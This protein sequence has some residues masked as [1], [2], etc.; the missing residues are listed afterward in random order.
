MAEALARKRIRAGHEASATKT[1]RQIE[2]ILTGDD[3][4]KSRLLLL[5]LTL[6]ENLETIKALDAEVIE[7]IED[8]TLADEI[9]QADDYREMTFASLIK[10]DRIVEARDPPRDPPRD[11]PVDTTPTGSRST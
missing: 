8:D 10:I 9:E 5:R 3:P 7:L 2:E 6:K 1:T 11:L 4:G